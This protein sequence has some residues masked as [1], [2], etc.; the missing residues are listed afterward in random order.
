M[1]LADELWPAME[2]MAEHGNISCK[3]D[4]QVGARALEVGIWGAQQNVIIN[5]ADITD[6]TYISEISVEA[7]RIADRATERCARVL[8]ALEARASK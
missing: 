2:E 1:K 8:A 5:L 6:Q 4:L 3:S 7:Q